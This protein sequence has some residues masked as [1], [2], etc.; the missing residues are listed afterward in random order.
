MGGYLGVQQGS[1]YAPSFIHLTYKP[2]NNSNSNTD[3]KC[4]VLVGKGLTFDSGGYNLKVGAGSQIELMKMDMGGCAAVFGTASVIA[5]LKPLN[6]EIHF[7]SA[8]CENMISENAMRPGD[9]LVTSNKK[10]IEVINTDAEGR[11]TLADA[12]VYASNIKSSNNKS[13][14]AII[15]LATLTGFYF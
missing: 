8:V 3:N 6:V 10:T 9:I 1:N 14:D 12:L 11:L 2:L 5:K 4:I 7:I 15:D 13:P